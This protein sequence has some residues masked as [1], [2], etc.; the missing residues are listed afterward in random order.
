MPQH[1]QQAVLNLAYIERK[2]IKDIFLPWQDVTHVRRT[3]S[4]E[5]VVPVVFSSGHTRLPVVDNGEIVGILHTKEFLALR[6]TGAK[7]W[8]STIRPV[9]KVQANDPV[10]PTLRSMQAKRNHMVAVFSSS[11]VRLGIV[12]LE[13]ILEEIWGE[14]YDEDEDS[15]IRKI[16]SDRVKSRGPRK[17]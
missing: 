7:D 6:E 12:T 15:A 2:Q 11:G 10:L 4:M 17:A 5:E 16:F 8:S 13:D 3:D 1:H 14:M 9:I